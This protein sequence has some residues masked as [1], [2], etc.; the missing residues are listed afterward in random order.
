M[1]FTKLFTPIK[2]GA[3][4]T[5]NRIVFSPIG[6]NFATDEGF[7]TEK[8]LRHYEERAK[9]GAGLIIVEVSPIM[10]FVGMRF[11]MTSDNKYLPGLIQ[12]AQCIKKHEAR[13]FIQLVHPGPKADTPETAISA[14]EVPI[15]AFNPRVLETDEVYEVIQRFVEAGVRV[16]AA[17]FE[18]IELHAA[19]FYLLSAFLSPYTN[20]RDDEFG[21]GPA[22]RT[23]IVCEV[24]EGIKER[25][26][27]DFPISCRINAVEALEGGMTLE[28]SKKISQ[29]LEAAGA[30]AIDV[31]AY[32]RPLSSTYHG[33]NIAVGGACGKDD[34]KGAFVPYAAEIKSA[35]TVP[36]IAVSKLDDPVFANTILEENK[37]DL[38]AIGRALLAD[39]YLPKKAQEGKLEEI[40]QCTYCGVCHINQQRGKEIKCP[41]NSQLGQ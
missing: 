6:C 16:K 1:E 4:E 24:I 22:Q 20:T 14:S 2:V 9:G 28:D 18:G 38:I 8:N 26:G 23:K 17:G 31:S 10:P 37:A 3:V 35:V 33:M 34:P 41:I 40:N 12:L 7:I 32:D 19:H 25:V 27:A 36:V 11:P 13:A 5:K 39:P 29:L 15:R 30:D 21:G